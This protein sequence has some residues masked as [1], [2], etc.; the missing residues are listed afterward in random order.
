MR[1]LYDLIYIAGEP[2]DGEESLVDSTITGLDY[3]S[4]QKDVLK[5]KRSIPTLDACVLKA[6]HLAGTE[7]RMEAIGKGKSA[8]VKTGLVTV[9]RDSINL[10]PRPMSPVKGPTLPVP[11]SGFLR[12]YLSVCSI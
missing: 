8:P 11:E 10:L 1:R 5:A 12:L 9:S 2:L 6:L 7:I 3:P 4:V